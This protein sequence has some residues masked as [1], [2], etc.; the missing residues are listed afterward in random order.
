MKNLFLRFWKRILL[1]L[2]LV[3]IVIVVALI[4]GISYAILHISSDKY[5]YNDVSKLPHSQA[6][7]ILGAA[8]LQNGTLSAALKDR[9]D[10][11]IK[12]YQAGK[13]D[14]ILVTGN[15]AT[16]AYNEVNPV[17]KY[18]LA[19]GVPD[20]DIFLDHAG[21]DTYSSMYRARDVFA[22]KSLIVVSQSFHLPRAVYIARYLGLDAVGVNADRGHYLAYNYFREVFANVKA[23][24]DLILMRQPK[25]LG[26]VIPITGDGT[27]NP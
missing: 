7:M 9:V 14:K 16:V 12:V 18:L 27:L 23:L 11:A 21:F 6:A 17:R 13:A 19:Q 26:S 1:L 8:V 22:V 25:Y 4:V 2:L 15:N 24:G 5:I 3:A 10:M 20:A